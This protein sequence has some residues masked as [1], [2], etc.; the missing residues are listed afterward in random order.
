MT[1]FNY[2]Q[3]NSLLQQEVDEKDDE[4]SHPN[5]TAAEESVVSLADTGAA[6]ATPMSEKA[7]SISTSNAKEKIIPAK[8]SQHTKHKLANGTT[9]EDIGDAFSQQEGSEKKLVPQDP[10]SNNDASANPSST[11]N[12]TEKKTKKIRIRKPR[13]MIPDKKEFIP[14]NEQ[15]TQ[16][17][18]VGGRG[19][20][21]HLWCIP[22]YFV[23]LA[24]T[25]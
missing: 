10:Q 14:V 15:P 1:M 17:D 19:G 6:A 23:A 3:S 22:R 8:K 12:L 5:R 18:I 11:K 4:G 21:F 7:K 13:R 16:A 2:A 25:L 9:L 24:Q 20:E